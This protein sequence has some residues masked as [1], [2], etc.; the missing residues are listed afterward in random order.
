MRSLSNPLQVLLLAYILVSGARSTEITGFMA[1]NVLLP[2]VVTHDDEFML[3]NLVVNWQREN[4]EVVHSFFYGKDHPD[5]QEKGFHGRTQLFPQEFPRGNLSLVLKR[6]RP[7]DAGKYVCFV[8]LND[9]KGYKTI[10]TE[11]VIQEKETEQTGRRSQDVF[12]AGLTSVLAVALPV[13]LAVALLL[14]KK[15][16]YRKNTSEELAPLLGCDPLHENIEYYR[17][18][19]HKTAKPCCKSGSSGGEGS[20]DCI[21]RTLQIPEW[22]KQCTEADNTNDSVTLKDKRDSISSEELFTKNTMTLTSR[23]MLIAGEAGIGKSC[24]SKG[25]QKR[26][27][28]GGKD[29][30]YECVIY[31]TFTEL[32]SIKE[33]VSVTELLGNKCKELVPVL[34]ELLHSDKL[35]IIFDG[36]DEFKLNLKAKQTDSSISN[37]TPLPIDTLILNIL[38]K[39]LLTNTDI[40][41]TSRL[42]SLTKIRKYFKRTFIMQ[43]FTDD[44][45][46]QYCKRFCSDDEISQSIY[47]FIEEHN[48]SSLVSI[49]LL[50]S[51]L[52]ELYNN[53]GF[54]SYKERLTTRSEMMVSLL[55]CCM[56]NILSSI[57]GTDKPCCAIAL[58]GSQLPENIKIMIHQVAKLSYENLIAGVEEIK[59]QDLGEGCVHTQRLLKDLSEFFFKES[60]NAEVFEYRHASIRDMFAA[61]HCVWEIHQSGGIEECLDAWVC[62][63]IL[64]QHYETSL[65]QNISPEHS[66]MSDHFIQFFMGLVIYTDIDSL[67]MSGKELNNDIMITLKQWFHRWIAKKCYGAEML[68]LFHCIHEIHD[69]RLT[70]FLSSKFKT[71][72]LFNTPLNASDIRALLYCLENSRLDTLDLA[73]CDLG[74]ANLQQLQSLIRN[75]TGVD[76]SSNMLTANSGKILRTI[77][78]H[79]DCS[80]KKLFLEINKLGSAGVQELWEA[81][82]L[83]NSVEMLT[84]CDNQIQDEGIERMAHSLSMNRTLKTLIEGRTGSSGGRDVRRRAAAPADARFQLAPGLRCLGRSGRLSCRCRWPL[85]LRAQWSWSQ[86][87]MTS[88]R[89]LQPQRSWRSPHKKIQAPDAD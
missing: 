60:S 33:P 25:L 23:R 14:Y 77:L 34:S 51:A 61:L 76:F 31:F 52:C 88:T 89:G 35:L 81:L 16:K 13:V 39:D 45:I 8:Y 17:E 2:C 73:L 50:S 71:V 40:L 49:P 38:S 7:S 18:S 47:P 11:L 78:E 80:T 70:E 67:Y 21:P 42:N 46:K 28:F 27:A 6:V 12:L 54:P 82:E 84:L 72:T 36:L 10:W 1:E 41:V 79:P 68:N 64:P 48:L 87:A 24:F 19:I 3:Q 58:S 63:Q 9:A 5:Y 20:D 22:R 4:R 86:K 29:L 53:Q 55:K 85:P 62:G 30:F 44:Q 59:V 26:W 43:E 56:K 15:K 65:L 66:V 69:A 75:S 37:D 57:E 74:D 83:N 32:K